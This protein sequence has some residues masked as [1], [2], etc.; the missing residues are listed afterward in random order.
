MSSLISAAPLPKIGAT[1]SRAPS[2]GLERYV[3]GANAGSQPPYTYGQPEAVLKLSD[4]DGQRIMTVLTDMLRRVSW[5]ANMPFS[6]DWRLRNVLGEQISGAMQLFSDAEKAYMHLVEIERAGEAIAQSDLFQAELEKSGQAVQAATRD[7]CRTLAEQ[8]PPLDLRKLHDA[9]PAAFKSVEDDQDAASSSEMAASM[10]RLEDVL[11]SIKLLIYNKLKTTPEEERSRQ[12]QLE[13][14]LAKEQKTILEVKNVREQLESV[15]QEHAQ[16]VQRRNDNIRKLKDEL[17]EIKQQAE[18]ATKKLE[19]KSKQKED[20]DLSQFHEKE[21][22]LKSD[23]A[24]ARARHAEL[25]TRHRD[26]ELALRKR[27]YKVESEVDAWIQK[28]DQDMEER[29]T[30]I[31]DISTIYNEEKAQLE[32]L[33]L[34]YNE[35]SKAYSKI[36][37]ERKVEEER[38]QLEEAERQKKHKAAARIQALWRGHT[39]RKEL[40]AKKEKKKEGKG[41]KSGKGKKKKSAK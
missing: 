27:K 7:L 3:L 33:Q 41:G 20:G 28:Y 2:A 34:R 9:L 14:N 35:L 10:T 32:E 38:H 39:T 24:A 8:D 23:I 22:L 29:Q 11:R 21:Q 15:R 13:S 31:D 18:D 5:V 37:E 25:L 17:R 4:V 6:I 40:K 16:E 26:E 12:H 36:L 30:E 1:G 19:Q